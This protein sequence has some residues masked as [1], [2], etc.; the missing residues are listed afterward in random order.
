MGGRADGAPG[1][2]LGLA[3]LGDP[4]TLGLP[5]GGAATPTSTSDLKAFL[6]GCFLLF[7]LFKVMGEVS[8]KETTV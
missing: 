1:L 8:A 6:G 2:A 4:T 3:V 5:P 7:N